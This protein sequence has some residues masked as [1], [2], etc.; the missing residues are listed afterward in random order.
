[1]VLRIRL[2]RRLETLAIVR[3]SD[4]PPTR[5][6]SPVINRRCVEIGEAGVAVGVQEARAAGEQCPR[7][8]GL[9]VG[10]VAITQVE[11]AY[12]RRDV[13]DK[14]RALIDTWAAYCE[15]RAATSAVVIFDPRSG[16]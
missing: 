12:R 16:I 2:L 5:P 1:M 7:M 10:R 4:R 9:A 3:S 8:L 6:V 13:L 14:R 15:P 11:R